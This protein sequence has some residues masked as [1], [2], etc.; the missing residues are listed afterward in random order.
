MRFVQKIF[1]NTWKSW[2]Q[3]IISEFKVILKWKYLKSEI[4]FVI[5]KV[6]NYFWN[7]FFF[8]K[9]ESSNKVQI[10]FVKFKQ[11]I[12]V[13]KYFFG[14]FSNVYNFFFLQ[15]IY[16]IILHLSENFFQIFFWN[17]K[18]SNSLQLK[19]FQKLCKFRSNILLKSRNAF[20]FH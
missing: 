13:Q 15:K 3:W 18:I 7:L 14:Q 16:W 12:T 20:K 4:L 5:F 10:F 17:L 19:A 11:Q 6:Q 1:S 9:L 8:F 2:I